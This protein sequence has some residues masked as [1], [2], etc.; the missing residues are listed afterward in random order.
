M[1]C[2]GK[3]KILDAMTIVNNM[4]SSS[5]KCAM[6]D[7]IKHCW[8]KAVTFCHQLETPPNSIKRLA[9]PSCHCVKLTRRPAKSTVPFFVCPWRAFN[10][11]LLL[12]VQTLQ[13]SVWLTSENADACQVQ[14]LDSWEDM[15]V[16]SKAETL[17]AIDI[18][19]WHRDRKC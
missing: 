14:Q 19:K 3:A 13:S 8:R 10:L 6:R 1:E 18:F 15:A 9:P 7:G 16:T 17:K 5:G 2:A 4:W 11:K 12:K